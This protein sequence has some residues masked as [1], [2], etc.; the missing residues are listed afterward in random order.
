M[1]NLFGPEFLQNA[2][3]CDLSSVTVVAVNL[4][5]VENIPSLIV[6]RSVSIRGM[7][8]E[9]GV[10]AKPVHAVRSEYQPYPGQNV[11]GDHWLERRTH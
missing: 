4:D 1:L 7:N 5:H 3:S 10:G 2:S 8:L 6:I 11:P 9:S